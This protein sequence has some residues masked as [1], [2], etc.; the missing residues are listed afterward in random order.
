MAKSG[1]DEFDILK[2]SDSYEIY[3]GMNNECTKSECKAHCTSLTTYDQEYEGVS[4]LCQKFARNLKDVN[5]MQNEKHNTHCL[6]LKYWI[7]GKLMKMNKNKLVYTENLPFITALR[8][9]MNSINRTSKNIVCYV[10]F[11]G[12]L[13]DLEEEKLMHDYF[14]NYNIIKSRKHRNKD[15]CE[16]Y[17]EYVTGI[18]PI[19]EQFKNDCCEDY[20]Y[21]GD[22][23]CR[24]Y[25]KCNE[26][27]DPNKLI[28]KL[29]CDTEKYPEDI[30]SG[31]YTERGDQEVD[32]EIPKSDNHMTI[33]HINCSELK[34]NNELLG[35]RCDDPAYR[36]HGEKGFATVSTAE[37]EERS[38]FVMKA[39]EA[40]KSIQN[41]IC[42]PINDNSGNLSILNCDFTKSKGMVQG[43]FSAE[44]QVEAEAPSKS[45]EQIEKGDGLVDGIKLLSVHRGVPNIGLKPEDNRE[46]TTFNN[47]PSQIRTSLFPE[48]SIKERE[49]YEDEKEETCDDSSSGNR[50]SQCKNMLHVNG[51][52]GEQ[53]D[54]TRSS[55]DHEVGRTYDTHFPV[56]LGEKPN[57]LLSN[58]FRISVTGVLILGIALVFFV[59]YKFTPFGT[60][61]HKRM[62]KKKRKSYEHYE[63][64]S[65]EFPENYLETLSENSQNKR[66]RIA[67]QH[68]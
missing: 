11:S 6:H 19:Y 18:I 10:N 58:G 7:Y 21:L 53:A 41:G 26:I 52:N 65:Q 15:N 59:Y 22:Y 37:T 29:N 17:K 54:S 56:I 51:K 36:Q 68:S 5:N 12:R 44:S 30:G 39:S 67:Y 66:L 40:I 61:L 57:L 64:F 27:Y 25:F 14:R 32:S 48:V 28:L 46:E 1:Q 50:N 13:K 31:S 4:S 20:Y 35:Y 43:K 23:E 42:T 38:S 16:K 45:N 34:V 55:R 60:W 33:K 8:S 47:S 3:Q 62:S 63:E 24:N 2:G 9:V 49:A